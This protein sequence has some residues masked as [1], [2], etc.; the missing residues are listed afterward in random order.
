[1][2]KK[3]SEVFG[4]S[5]EL[6]PINKRLNIADCLFIS[7]LQYVCQINVYFSRL[8]VVSPGKNYGKSRRVD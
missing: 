3:H 1:M 5:T 4:A 2:D 7:K 8:N 6:Y